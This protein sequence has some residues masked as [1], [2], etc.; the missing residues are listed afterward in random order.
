[1]LQPEDVAECVVQAL[2]ED[3]FM[4]LPH[5]QVVEYMQKKSAN[6]DRWVASMRKFRRKFVG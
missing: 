6:Y 5:P 1:M 4:I 3:R 2:A